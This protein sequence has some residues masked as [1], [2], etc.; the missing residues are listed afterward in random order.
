MGIKRIFLLLIALSLLSG[1]ESVQKDLASLLE[2]P[3]EEQESGNSQ[4]EE[5]RRLK[6]EA[7]AKFEETLEK[8]KGPTLE[9]AENIKLDSVP[10]DNTS[11]ESTQNR[12]M[13]QGSTQNQNENLTQ[14]VALKPGLD[15]IGNHRFS[16]WEAKCRT[17]G[18]G[19][20]LVSQILVKSGKPILTLV[21]NPANEQSK[22][23]FGVWLPFGYYIPIPPII[24]IGDKGK[25]PLTTQ[26]CQLRGCYATADNISAIIRD[27]R[28]GGGAGK[29]CDA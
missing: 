2:L 22:P 1:C 7:S 15:K 12:N 17:A 27:M 8:S 29:G 13:D 14:S 9:L 6:E 10:E 20:V 11:P 26:H 21:V 18:K 4:E 28:R 25:Y 5:A 3:A 23:S 16:D 24:S 19:C